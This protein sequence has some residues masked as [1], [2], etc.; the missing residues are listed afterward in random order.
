MNRHAKHLALIL[1][2]ILLII[3]AFSA[4][5]A[6]R[7]DKSEYKTGILPAAD[8]QRN[9]AEQQESAGYASFAR[10]PD[11]YNSAKLGFTLPVR[12]QHDNTC[13]AYGTLSSFET[14]LLV[15]GENISTLSPEHVNFWGSKREDGT[16]WQ[17][18]HEDG[19][20]AYIPLGYLTSWSGPLNESDFPEQ[21]ST[22][23]DY[24]SCSKT[25]D[26]GVTEIVYFGTDESHDT[27]K[28]YIYS[29][30]SVV[31][32]FN[33][34]INNYLSGTSYF[35]CGDT[36]LTGPELWG[37]CV[38]VVGWDDN[39]PKDYFS[40]SKSGTPKN[41]GAWLIKNSWSKYAGEY[42]Y[43]WISY[44]DV[45]L[46]NEIFG[47]S[48]AITDY[49]KLN[50]GI[51]MYQNE[52]DGATYEFGYFTYSNRDFS[53]IT[54]M[55]VFDFSE[56]DRILDKVIFESTA[57]GADYTIYY[58]PSV[59]N[60]LTA[61]TKQWHKLY[62][63]T[64]T[65]PGYICA[66]FEDC[67]VP[68]GKGAIGV[69]IS[70]ERVNTETGEVA[71]KNSIGCNE[72]LP[73]NDEYIFLP[74]SKYGMSYYMD[75]N[76]SSPEI[77][78]V[79]QFYSK[80][81]QDDIGS[82]F[83]IK[84]VTNNRV[85]DVPDTEPA[86]APEITTVPETTATA[87]ETAATVPKT[88]PSSNIFTYVLGDTNLDGKVNVKDATLVQKAVAGI[89]VLTEREKIAGNATCDRK[90]N[91]LDSTAIQKYA[92]QISTGFPIGTVY[93]VIITKAE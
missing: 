56:E 48:Y 29:Y 50:D 62:E 93:S 55:N 38:S 14:L 19:G 49:E 75:M 85:P 9:H 90:L 22:R 79:M 84:A 23:E 32:C 66:D 30:G 6:D 60:S 8:K 34:D 74:Q 72:W 47:P 27:I 11:S 52:V 67:K 65:Y 53:N 15:N 92:S 43:F 7:L 91:I 58:I 87:P 28:Q 4:S 3:T 2:V 31:G 12:Q 35:Y 63:D 61:D 39:F 46:F 69:L 81:L 68:A 45:W 82:T 16:G 33:A 42:G 44:E 86:T 25:P 70:N 20:Y 1:S 41:D 37:H 36:T 59:N 54:Y 78:D 51:R 73:L 77:K 26:Y 64:I 76:S 17:R 10:L 40:Q 83:V 89:S 21:T 71:V 18:T 5:A 24:N 57:V 13:W 88:T 80:Y